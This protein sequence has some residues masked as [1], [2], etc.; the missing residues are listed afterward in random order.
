MVFSFLRRRQDDPK[1]L[2]KEALGEFE[3][4]TFQP[5]MMQT[6]SMLRD[7]NSPTT[8]VA[9]L[10]ETNPGLAIRVLRTVNSAAFGLRRSIGGVNQA[11]T[12]LGRSGLESIVLAAAVKSAL[13][14]MA[15]PLLANAKGKAY[16]PLLEH[17]HN[18]GDSC[19]MQLERGEFGWDHCDIGAAIAERWELPETLAKSI[20]AHHHPEDAEPAV[21]LVSYLRESDEHPGVDRLVAVC[22]SE[23]NLGA[24]EVVSAVE[25]GFEDATE[26]ART[27]S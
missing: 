9:A 16:G 10:I 14:D 27:F 26:V 25:C 12:L 18:T 5:G 24:D 19:L 3:L 22:E 7:P 20:D 15:V 21:H 1:E 2:L 13:P 4:P 11:V 23:F 6:L 17:W 8:K